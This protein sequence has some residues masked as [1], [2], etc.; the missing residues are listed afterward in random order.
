MEVNDIDDA[1]V[2]K[3]GFDDIEEELIDQRLIK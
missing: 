2:E 3:K 1:F